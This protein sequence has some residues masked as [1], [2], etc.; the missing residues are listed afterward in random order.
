MSISDFFKKLEDDSRLELCWR[1][2]TD[3]FDFILG[4]NLAFSR[5]GFFSKI[6]SPDLRAG[7]FY[8]TFVRQT[9]TFRRIKNFGQFINKHLYF[10]NLKTILFC[11]RSFR[12]LKIIS[13]I[14][15]KIFS[16]RKHEILK[17]RNL[18]SLFFRVFVLSRFRD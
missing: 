15:G 2:N 3:T 14:L 13:L 8:F 12:R 18:N 17:A 4:Q 7:I 9:H 5:R 6:E 16:S 10:I 1:L 11:L